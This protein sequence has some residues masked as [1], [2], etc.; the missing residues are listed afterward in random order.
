[1]N[2]AHVKA[3]KEKEKANESHKLPYIPTSASLKLNEMGVKGNIC[4]KFIEIL[5]QHPAKTEK[6]KVRV[7]SN[8]I[9]ELAVDIGI[10]VG[11]LLAKENDDQE[12]LMDRFRALHFSLKVGNPE[13]RLLLLSGRLQSEIFVKII[14]RNPHKT[15][16]V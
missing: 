15:L 16:N 5:Q 6:G 11:T 7:H 13:L 14:I 3:K 1:M 10:E 8:D 12:T 4:K 2:K 9:I